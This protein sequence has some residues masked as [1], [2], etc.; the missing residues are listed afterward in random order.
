MKRERQSSRKLEICPC[1]GDFTCW[2]AT[3]DMWS[4]KDDMEML[5]SKLAEADVWVFA[6]PVSVDWLPGPMKNVI[7]RAICTSNLAG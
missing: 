3:L 5:L 4:Q 6:N 1:Q 2:F 7:D